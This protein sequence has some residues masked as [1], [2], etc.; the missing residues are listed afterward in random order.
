MIIKSFEFKK[1]NIQSY[2]FYL[3]YGE[4]KG[5]KKEIIDTNFKNKFKDETYYFEES[6][7]I[8]NENDFF[9]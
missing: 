2:N 7:I 9:N 1:T 4:N 5:L 3:F 6:L 8:K